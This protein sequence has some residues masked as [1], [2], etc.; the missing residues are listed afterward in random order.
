MTAD[1]NVW[2]P[3]ASTAPVRATGR[4]AAAQVTHAPEGR[5]LAGHEDRPAQFRRMRNGLA[6]KR[7][8]NRKWWVR[9]VQ[10]P[11]VWATLLLTIGYALALFG[12]YYDIGTRLIEEIPA[13]TQEIYGAPTEITWEQINDLRPGACPWLDAQ[14]AEPSA[15]AQPASPPPAS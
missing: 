5:G 12:L 10:N 8:P 14:V 6:I 2:R 9:I 11:Y 15:A 4:G 3:P 7:D 1:A 13:V